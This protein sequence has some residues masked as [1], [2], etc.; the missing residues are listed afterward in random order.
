MGAARW[1]S[2]T[3]KQ[4]CR[5]NSRAF[6]PTCRLQTKEGICAYLGHISHATYDAWQSEALFPVLWPTLVSTTFD[7]MI[8]CS[9]SSPVYVRPLPSCLLSKN[10]KPLMRVL[11]EGVYESRKTLADGS[12]RSYFN[13]RGYGALRPLPGDED[14]PFTLGS[15]AFMRAYQAAIAAPVIARTVGTMQSLIDGWQRS[16]QWA[17]LAPR[18]KVD[19]LGAVARIE[20]KWGGYPLSVIEDPKIRPRFLDWRDEMA[21]TSL[22]QAD[23]VFG[24]LRI[25]LEWGRDR[26]L[27]SLNHATR[28]KKLYKADRAD[29]LW[30]PEH[31]AAFRAVATPEMRLALELAQWTGQRQGDLLK[32]G[33]ASYD[34]SRISFRQ[35]KRKRKVDMPVYSTLRLALDASPRKALTI[36]TTP[37]GRPWGKV[38]FQHQWRKATLAAG[39]DGLHFHDLRGTTC[40]LLAEAGATPSEIAS[41]LGWTVSTVNRMLDTY[42]AMTATLSDSAVA[43][44]ELRA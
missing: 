27:I 19:Y 26:G 14:E 6:D 24:V 30:L 41:Y 22:R 35:G 9:I 17:K 21:K 33:W 16:P 15:A 43:K 29:K 38:N 32:L 18:T 39:L 37:R 20:R 11:L 31:L 42:Q 8:T 23:A 25:I 36:L 13:L 40:T 7:S 2:M 34:G 10:G 44:L 12:R 5:A 1:F 28:P 4:N 3:E